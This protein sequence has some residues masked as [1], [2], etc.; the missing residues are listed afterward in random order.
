MKNI[1]RKFIPLMVL[2]LMLVTSCAKTI[3]PKEAVAKA[4]AM[5]T[6]VSSEDFKFPTKC[7]AI[8]TVTS[9][10]TT[11]K[12]TANLDLENKYVYSSAESG[13]EKI[14]GWIYVKDNKFI[15]ASSSSEGKTYTSIAYTETAFTTATKE[16]SDSIIESSKTYLK[17]LL[18]LA[19]SI[20]TAENTSIQSDK[21]QYE[22]K[23]KGDGNLSAN[24]TVKDTS[25]S[26]TMVI[27]FDNYLLTN[28]NITDSIDMKFNWGKC[29]LSYPDL[30]KFT[31]AE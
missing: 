10:G 1:T 21:F 25:T 16:F 12:S 19:K 28:I 27:G 22:F 31:V 4:N 26:Y 3:T 23:S 11:I 5:E 2:P 18:T 13:S 8:M 15:T 29:N 17:T 24:I 7:S 14:E 9:E 6:K 30:S 20:V